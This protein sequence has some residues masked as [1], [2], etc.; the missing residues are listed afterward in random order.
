MQAYNLADL[1]RLLGLE[2]WTVAADSQVIAQ[3]IPG[4]VNVGGYAVV[5]TSPTG[6]A[7]SGNGATR[8]DAL[9]TAALL[10]GVITPDQPHLQ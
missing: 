4:Q 1:E 8:A 3:A 7:F 10:A 5:L 6:E 2:G 9:R